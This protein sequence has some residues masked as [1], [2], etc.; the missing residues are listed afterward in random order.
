MALAEAGEIF[1]Q[2]VERG[3]C[4][5]ANSLAGF[6]PYFSDHQLTASLGLGSVINVLIVTGEH[7]FGTLNFL[8]R[9][10]AYESIAPVEAVTEA[11]TRSRRRSTCACVSLR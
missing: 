1:R 11:S 5:I 9:T 6:A 10:G 4:L 8:D 7:L 2:V 3:Q